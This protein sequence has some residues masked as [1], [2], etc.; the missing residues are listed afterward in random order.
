MLLLQP[1]FVRYH[2]N[3]SALR[4][5]EW[6]MKDIMTTEVSFFEEKV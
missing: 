4:R 3:A 6:R 1:N 5:L 2:M